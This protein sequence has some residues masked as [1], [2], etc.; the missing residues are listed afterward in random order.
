MTLLPVLMRCSKKAL[1]L[2]MSDLM[3]SSI[4]GMS[5]NVKV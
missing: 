1:H 3:L 4:F 2:T 5:L